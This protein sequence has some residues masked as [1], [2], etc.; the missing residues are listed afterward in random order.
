MNDDDQFLKENVKEFS[1][2]HI[3]RDVENEKENSTEK[4][5]KIN[6]FKLTKWIIL[7]IQIPLV[8]LGSVLA[9][10]EYTT[11]YNKVGQ[12]LKFQYE[13]K[14][15]S[16]LEQAI[17]CHY[18]YPIV[19]NEK[20]SNV[21][22]TGVVFLV[23]AYTLTVG[24]YYFIHRRSKKSFLNRLLLIYMIILPSIIPVYGGYLGEKDYRI[25]FWIVL[26]FVIGLVE[27]VYNFFQEIIN[28]KI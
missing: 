26:S 16:W 3:I 19:E 8:L 23:I 1:N 28:N 20:Y 24:Y 27:T 13:Q 15:N 14:E 7:L 10:N 4:K 2:N 5:I 22:I 11:N 17:G 21:I 6:T 25:F 18:G 9:K 12:Y